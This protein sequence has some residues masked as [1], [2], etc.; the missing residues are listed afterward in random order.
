MRNRDNSVTIGIPVGPREHHRA[1]LEECLASCLAIPEPRPPI[2]LVDDMAG[3][4]PED[5]GYPGG[6][7]LIVSRELDE[8]VR[9]DGVRT[10]IL[11]YETPWR[12]G[13]A[14]AF[15]MTVVLART[16]FTL[17]LG[18]D[19]TLEPNVIEEFRKACP[20]PLRDRA[21]LTWWGL[22]VRYTDTGEEQ[23]AACNAAIVS[24]ELWQLTG[25]FAPEMAVG[26]C[27]SMLLSCMI[28]AEGRAGDLRMVGERPLYNYR[29]HALTETAQSA[30]L[31]ASIFQVRDVLTRDWKAAA[32]GRS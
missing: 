10:N 27:D 19:D 13:V 8:L 24:H 23:S 1:Y 21:L 4:E 2:L 22:P 32:W 31:Q 11:R 28:A 29:R 30:D 16:Q 26:A 20:F 7:W 6:R 18:A 9:G 12:L 17:M 3:L 25:G 14:G 15:N 5:V